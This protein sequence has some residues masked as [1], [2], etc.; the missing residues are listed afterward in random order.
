[1][2]TNEP[3]QKYADHIVKAGDTP[4]DLAIKYNITVWD[5]ARN[6]QGKE[7]GE[8]SFFNDI[9]KIVMEIIVLIGKRVKEL[10]G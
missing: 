8:E 1:M 6:N 10:N 4:Y 3:T 9:Q 2:H 7:K 5:I